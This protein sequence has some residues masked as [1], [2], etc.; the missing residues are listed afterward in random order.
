MT[1]AAIAPSIFNMHDG[2]NGINIEMPRSPSTKM[3]EQT[4]KDTPVDSTSS[5]NQIDEEPDETRFSSKSLNREI[6]ANCLQGKY[7]FQFIFN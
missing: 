3:L 7:N 1:T 6:N 2:V 4:K 5:C